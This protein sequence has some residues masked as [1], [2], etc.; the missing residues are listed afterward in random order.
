M[1]VGWGTDLGRDPQRMEQ[2][3]HKH[4]ECKGAFHLGVYSVQMRSLCGITP[5]IRVVQGWEKLRA[6]KKTNPFRRDV[7]TN[8]KTC[9]HCHVLSD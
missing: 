8:K 1:L 9:I 4:K 5:F 2:L 7:Q 3:S 6:A